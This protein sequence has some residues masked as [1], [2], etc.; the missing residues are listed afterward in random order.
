MSLLITADSSLTPKILHL[1]DIHM[2]SGFSH[3]RINPQTGL[4]T[5]LEDFVGVRRVSVIHSAASKT[6]W[7]VRLSCGKVGDAIA[8]LPLNWVT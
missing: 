8:L 3:G 5:L 7:A 6:C 2:G 1:S 4:N